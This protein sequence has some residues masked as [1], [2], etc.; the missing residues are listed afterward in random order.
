[1]QVLALERHVLLLYQ[2]TLNTKWLQQPS[3]IGCGLLRYYWPHD[4]SAFSTRLRRELTEPDHWLTEGSRS[5]RCRKGLRGPRLGPIS[6]INNHLR[7]SVGARLL[8][9]SEQE[10][11]LLNRLCCWGYA[12]SVCVRMCARH[13]WPVGRRCLV[14][15]K[16]FRIL[17]NQIWAVM[18]YIV[19]LWGHF[20]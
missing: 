5:S 8:S 17:R 10:C 2:W 14:M 19:E 13:R 12:L 16:S 18:T 1:M 7:L 6:P 11:D 9:I 4:C 15:R 3:L 20:I